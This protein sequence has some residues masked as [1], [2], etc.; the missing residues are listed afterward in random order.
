MEPEPIPILIFKQGQ[1]TY[2]KINLIVNTALSSLHTLFKYTPATKP[3]LSWKWIPF[4]LHSQPP[5]EL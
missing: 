5:K 1:Y 2:R 4:I 3:A